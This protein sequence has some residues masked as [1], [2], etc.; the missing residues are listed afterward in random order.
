MWFS[1]RSADAAAQ[2]DRTAIFG[3][4]ASVFLGLKKDMPRPLLAKALAFFATELLENSEKLP[5]RESYARG[6]QPM[7]QKSTTFSVKNKILAWWGAVI[8]AVCK[9]T[10]IDRC[11][12]VMRKTENLKDLLGL[13]CHFC[14]TPSTKEASQIHLKC[15]MLFIVK[16]TS[17]R[18]RRGYEFIA[19]AEI[20]F[21]WCGRDQLYATMCCANRRHRA[22]GVLWPFEWKFVHFDNTDSYGLQ[23]IIEIW[24]PAHALLRHTWSKDYTRT[25]DG[26]NEEC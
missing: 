22:V 10:D 19:L 7:R 21:P 14:K 1:F 17:Y 2:S 26:A 11:L 9:K 6:Y 15:K 5:H 12:L 18:W 25:D 8:I 13:Q 20:G 23:V 16:E 4:I 24:A 3:W